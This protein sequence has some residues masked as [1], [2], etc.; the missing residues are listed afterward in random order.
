MQGERPEIPE[1][2]A[3]LRASI[4]TVE[5]LKERFP[6]LPDPEGIARAAARFP[7]SIPPYYAGLVERASWDDPIF[8]MAVP[9]PEELDDP[10][11]LLEDPI[12]ENRHMVTPGL[13]HR[14]PDRAML[15]ST[16]HCAMYCRH[17]TRK[18]IT[19]GPAGTISQ[20]HL[21]AAADYLRA[22]PEIKDVLI[23]GG[24]PLAL[25]TREVERLLRGIRSA[26]SVEIVR[27]CSRVPV[28]LPMRITD[29]LVATLRRF[30]P[31]WLNTHFNH[32]R[33]LT[34]QAAEAVGRLVDAGIPVC[35]QS[36]LLRGVNDDPRVMEELVRG[37][38]R[39]RV[40]PYYLFQC[41]LVR[42]VEHFR[43]PISRG[44]EIMEHLRGRV[45][46]LAIPCYAFDVPGGEGKVPLLPEY[47]VS[48]SETHT[49][50]RTWRG[51][52]FDHPEPR[53]GGTA[54]PDAKSAPFA[55]EPYARAIV[56][57]RSN[58]KVFENWLEEPK[59]EV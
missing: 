11:F 20:R 44:L 38:L 23:S 45:S 26:E 9:S 22:H 2:T 14:Y 10:P 6:E 34:P 55:D 7:F 3:Q 39:I 31:V 24:D 5:A 25:P 47:V 58:D 15:I 12:G 37:L 56:D 29:E 4:R 53:A 30:A 19:G 41:D 16:S 52:F 48:R 49:V 28:T 27:I 40:K 13:V 54:A 59:N 32:P 50:L 17:C 36:V 1:W 43:T 46:G 8:R 18:R 35:N 33:E 42:G 51:L 21:E 57:R